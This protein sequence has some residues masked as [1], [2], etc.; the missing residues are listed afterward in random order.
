M[1]GGN[2]KTI[3]DKKRKRDKMVEERGEESLKCHEIIWKNDVLGGETEHKGM[4]S[5]K[6][7]GWVGVVI[8]LS[9]K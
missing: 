4:K 6:M 8:C 7:G 3:T 2:V 1:N 5:M 9:R